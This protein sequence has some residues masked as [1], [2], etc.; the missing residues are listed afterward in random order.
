[1]NL[2]VRGIGIWICDGIFHFFVPWCKPR[3]DL[4]RGCFDDYFLRT[5]FADT[6]PS[7]MNLRIPSAFLPLTAMLINWLTFSISASAN[8]PAI[9]E[10][11]RF[12]KCW[13]FRGVDF[14]VWI[15]S[16]FFA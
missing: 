12:T 7:A 4:R 11:V 5:I 6:V 10:I 3:R 2:R 13:N 1:M 15:E 8:K 9:S 14:A 16:I